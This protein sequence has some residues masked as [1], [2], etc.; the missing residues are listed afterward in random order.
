MSIHRVKLALLERLD[1]LVSTAESIQ[2]QKQTKSQITEN[3]ATH[4]PKHQQWI[5]YPEEPSRI[6]LHNFAT[7]M[8]Q[9]IDEQSVHW[10]S[11]ISVRKTDLVN[12][13]D[14]GR[15]LLLAL[16]DDLKLG[17]L[18]RLVVRVQA[19]VAADYL[20]MAEALLGEGGNSQHDHVP[21]AVLA[22]AVLERALREMCGR[23][24]PPIPVQ[25]AN[26]EPKTLNPLI[27]ELKVAGVF[28]ELRAKSLRSW[29][30]VRNA[31]AHGE[32]DKFT[33]A[34][35]DAMVRG[36]GQFLAEAP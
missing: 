36:V 18:D 2:K 30:A 7:L 11:F 34:D 12:A 26:G 31:A 17:L 23:Q 10:S 20:G 1:Q 19:E 9:L 28:N 27:D 14:K 16:K 29:A 4:E 24:T 5:E 21:A 6:W 25:K 8:S 35:V 22:G 13:V 32:F 3:W 33:R 15:L